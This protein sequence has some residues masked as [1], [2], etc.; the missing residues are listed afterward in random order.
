MRWLLA[1]LIVSAC[2]QDTPISPAQ[3]DTLGLAEMS[4]EID[5]GAFGPIAAV[6]VSK[7]GNVVF[8]DHFGAT[9]PGDRIDM[10]SVGKSITAMALGAAVSEGA[11]EDLDDTA[12]SFF[13]EYVP[14]ANDSPTKRAITL[15]DLATMRSALDCDDWRDTPG[16][17]EK[18]YPREDWT[19]FVLDLPTRRNDHNDRFS[20][21]GAGVFLLGQVIER[22][23]GERFDAYV[24]SRLFDP[25][26][27][28]GATWWGSSSGEVQAGGQLRLA[29]RDAER[30][31]RLVLN[32]G[33]WGEERVLPRGWVEQM[34]A[35]VSELPFDID[36]GMLWWRMT[37]TVGENGRKVDAEMMVG[38][39]G[40]LVAVIP[41]IDV[42]IVVQSQGYHD[43]QA[44]DTSLLLISRHILPHLGISL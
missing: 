19:R 21:C 44:R 9:Q 15:R 20:Y 24:Q 2:T 31:G 37:L 32:R 17:E 18:M 42:V 10:R 40:N 43:P 29:A 14:L 39:G 11:L 34:V 4:A 5:A 16:T 36:Y 12:V 13:S 22:A 35:P 23:T 38:N 27:V 1:A 7:R 3:S 6:V 26:G 41:E 25:I 33:L 8:E 28:S 30:L